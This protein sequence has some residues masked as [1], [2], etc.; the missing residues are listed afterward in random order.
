MSAGKRSGSRQASK[1]MAFC[2]LITALSVTVMLTGGL[3]P[4]ATYCAPMIAGVFL[5]PVLMEFGQ[6]TAWTTYG[7]T[8]L[9]CVLLGIDKEAAFFYMF[10]GYY[11]VLKWNLDRIKKRPLRLMTK[12]FLFSAAIA[13]MYLVL[14]F[15]LN[16]SAIMAEFANMGVWLTILFLVMFDACMLLYDRL[17]LPFAILYVQRLKPRIK[18]LR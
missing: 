14:G 11:P 8:A 3:I 2:G 16:M 15:L 13:L 10:L 5:L 1:K 18:F 17:L 7:A 6:K 9:I 12:L 4:I